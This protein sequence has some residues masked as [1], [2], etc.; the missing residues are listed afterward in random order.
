MLSPRVISEGMVK[1]NSTLDPSARSASVKKK[2]PRELTS[3]VK[4]G[5]AFPSL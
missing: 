1:V 2:S 3:W 5:T 4:P